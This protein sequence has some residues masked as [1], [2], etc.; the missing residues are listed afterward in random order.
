MIGAPIEI[1]ELDE[2][3][4][5][6]R[7]RGSLHVQVEIS[8]CQADEPKGKRTALQTVTIPTEYQE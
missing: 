2:Q 4:R 6:Q 8:M 3:G 5:P 1:L 7:W